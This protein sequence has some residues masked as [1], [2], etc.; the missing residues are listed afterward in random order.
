MNVNYN[1]LYCDYIGATGAYSISDY[2]DIT[3]NTLAINSSNF[4]SGTSNILNDKIFI[5]S[6]ILNSNINNVDIK[7]NDLIN[8]KITED[9]IDG[10]LY[11]NIKNTYIYNNNVFGEIRFKLKDEIEYLTKIS[12]D[13]K[14]Y[15]YIKY[16]PLRPTIAAGWYDVSDVMHDYMGNTVIWNGILT[17]YGA[18]LIYLQEQTNIIDAAI[19]AI[20]LQLGGITGFLQI[21]TQQI[22][23]LIALQPESVVSRILDDEF[24]TPSEIATNIIYNGIQSVSR[25]NTGLQS[26]MNLGGVGL[27]GW[28]AAGTIEF[29]RARI[30]KDNEYKAKL[31]NIYG[32][33]INNS[34]A[35]NLDVPDINNPGK[36]LRESLYTNIY[37]NLS[38]I[39]INEN[40]YN[41]NINILNGFI[42]SNIQT[43]QYINSLNTVDFR[44]NNINISNIYVSSNVLSNLNI[45]HGFINSNITTEQYI[46]TLKCDTLNL[47]TGNIANI[48]GIT[49]NEL[50]ANGKIKQ[51]GILLDNTYLTSNHLYNLSLNYTAER[52]YPPK[53]YTTSTPEETV[54]LLN[55]QVYKQTLFLNSTSI[56]YGSGYYEIYSSST[57]DN[58]ITNKDKLFNHTAAD[59]PYPR[60]AISL[61]N[62]SSGNYIGDN[63]IDGSY[64]GDW[65]IIKLQQPILLTRYRIFQSPNSPFPEKAPAE[66]KCYGSNDGI[67]FTEITQASQMTRLTSYTSGYYQKTVDASFTT[68]YQWFGFVFNKLL[69]VSGHT[70]LSFAELRLYGKE[71]I[72]NTI[73]SNIYATSNAVK[74]I[75]RNEMSDIPKRKMFIVSIPSSST[76]IDS[77]TSTTFYKWDLDL[78]NYT[79]TQIIPSE[80]YTGDLLRVFKISLWYIPSYF[81]S[82]INGEP[83]VINYTIYMSN[84]SN[85]VFGRPETAGVNIYAVGFP[86]NIKL[87]NILPN[88]LMLL[89]NYNS[90]FNYLTIVSRQAPADLYCIIEDQLF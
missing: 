89:K 5:T 66:W 70:D 54:S 11:S 22:N 75:I 24:L 10:L 64:Y 65:L 17:G 86:E 33:I 87:A 38:N 68:L 16:K 90:N 31:L 46:K 85:P 34:N 77:S 32:T 23:E 42:N 35:S 78:R 53:A 37:S 80:P 57:Y 7:Y 30:D 79:T 19:E 88:N 12:R 14:L 9:Y 59:V 62:S 60:W 45:N 26:L 28:V 52:Q 82:Y 67:T 71:I 83:Y 63:S 51:N 43:Q 49:T 40:I 48:N 56:S 41:C 44:I 25:M 4:T 15:V 39:Y 61:Y 3:S 47:N 50:I 36:S 72:S 1:N 84:K 76:F 55:K 69:S 18:D 58:G 73:V 2:I 74:G 21:H 29:I 6:N 20:N 13:A 27:L 81:G 8:I